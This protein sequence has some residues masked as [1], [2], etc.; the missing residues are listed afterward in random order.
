M[1]TFLTL[2]DSDLRELGIEDAAPRNELLAKARQINS[3]LQT[4]IYRKSLHNLHN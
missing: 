2:T 1:E 3:L 4:N